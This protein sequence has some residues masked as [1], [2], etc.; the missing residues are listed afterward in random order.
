[1]FLHTCA[2]QHSVHRFS[3]LRDEQFKIGYVFFP[4]DRA[5]PGGQA[6]PLGPSPAKPAGA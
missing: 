1:M 5:T 4:L 2:R 6:G 3:A